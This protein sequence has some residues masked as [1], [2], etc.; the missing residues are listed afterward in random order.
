MEY[1]EYL[2]IIAAIFFLISLLW[3]WNVTGILD[4]LK[5]GNQIKSASNCLEVIVGQSDKIL[6]S[7][8]RVRK[9]NQTHQNIEVQA[10]SASTQVSASTSNR[11]KPYSV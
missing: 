1:L 4:C 11:L 2:V 3:V 9:N 10:V 8:Q 7:K 6:A 5:T